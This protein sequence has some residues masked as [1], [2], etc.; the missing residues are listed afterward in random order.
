MPQN[1]G[2][3]GDL[4]MYGVIPALFGRDGLRDVTERLPYLQ[5]LGINAIWLS[6]INAGPDQDFGYAVTNYFSLKPKAGTK[7]DLSELVTVAHEHGIRALMD[8]VPN[9][10]SSEHLWFK[11][12]ERR[13]RLSP[14]YS[15]YQRDENGQTTH[16]FD[17]TRLPNLNFDNPDVRA[18][19]QEAIVYWVREFDIDGYRI[20]VAWGIKERAPDFWPA[21]RQELDKVKLGVLLLAEASA[22]DPYYAHNGFDIAYD[23]TGELGHWAWEGVFESRNGIAERLRTALTDNGRGYDPA[24]VIFR[25]LNNNDT[26]P[27]FIEVHGPELTRAAAALLLTLPG[28]PRVYTGDE[29]GASYLPYAKPA[30]VGWT[31]DP[32]H[33]RPWCRQLISLRHN[34]PSLRSQE[35]ELLDG[36]PREFVLAYARYD[37]AGDAHSL[38]MLNFGDEAVDMV[39]PIPNRFPQRDASPGLVD[40]LGNDCSY[41]SD[42]NTVAIQLPAWGVAVLHQG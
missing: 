21:C 15:F 13:G 25:F 10:T 2:G 36:E 3:V 14:Y 28:I 18:T 33:L 17:W 31:A 23:W 11:D 37:R 16:Y 5:E 39:V 26:G 4:I 6:P 22:R 24:T 29:V 40:A 12:A 8:F 7:E 32:F 1:R 27:R 34:L 41:R 35:W 30:P 38:V 20:D 19:V 9:H 42:T